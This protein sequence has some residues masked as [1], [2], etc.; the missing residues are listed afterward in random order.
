MNFFGYLS[1][2]PLTDSSLSFSPRQRFP[3]VRLLRT[4]SLMVRKTES[5]FFQRNRFSSKM[6]RLP[7]RAHYLPFCSSI[8][9][10][11]VPA[12]KFDCVGVSSDVI[13]SQ[14]DSETC[15]WA[16]TRPLS[17]RRPCFCRLTLG[18]RVKWHSVDAL[19]DF[20]GISHPL[21]WSSAF[22]LPSFVTHRDD[23]GP[24]VVKAYYF[25]G[26]RCSHPSTDSLRYSV[27]VWNACNL[28]S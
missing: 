8:P 16:T 20:N 9:T 22:V 3:L 14:Y 7:H 19:A 6:E 23:H 1:L 24:W 4:T 2:S 28:L 25:C 18:F 21:H 17:F 11:A 10:A 27:E 12:T 15:A 5:H 13:C 26:I